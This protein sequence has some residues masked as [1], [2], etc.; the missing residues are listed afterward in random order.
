MRSVEFIEPSTEVVSRGLS[1]IPLVVAGSK[2]RSVISIGS[3]T[4]HIYIGR[5][6]AAA[7]L[8]QHALLYRDSLFRKL[9][10]GC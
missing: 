8:D 7:S 4:H 9:A 6:V 3:G 2:A 5:V 10:A 1:R